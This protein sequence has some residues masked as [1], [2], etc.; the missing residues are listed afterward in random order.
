[1]AISVH[2]GVFIS[3]KV[4]QLKIVFSNIILRSPNNSVIAVAQ[5]SVYVATR[6]FSDSCVD[7]RLGCSFFCFE[8][9]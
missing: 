1:M 9:E 4:A 7:I 3:H 6:S 8:M 2:E 5:Y